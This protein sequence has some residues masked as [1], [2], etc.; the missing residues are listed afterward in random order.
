M[1]V[2]RGAKVFAEDGIYENGNVVCRD[3]KIAEIGGANADANASVSAGTSVD[4]H[5][6]IFNFPSN[7]SVIPG[8]IDMHLHGALGVDTMDATPQALEKICRALPCEGVTAFLATTITQTRDAITQ[9]VQSVWD[10]QQQQRCEVASIKSMNGSAAMHGA[11]AELL[12]INLEGPFIAPQKAC[13]H[14]PQHIVAPQ[15]AWL[16]QWHKTI[17]DGL[18]VFTVAPEIDGAKKLIEYAVKHNIV[19]SIGHSAATYEEASAALAAGCS[20]ATHLFNAFAPLHHRAPGAVTA[21]LL[22]P[23]ATVEVIADGIHLH[24]SILQLVLRLKGAERVILVSDAIRAKGM[25]DGEY[26]L[27]GQKVRV[28]KGEARVGDASD[29]LAGSVLTMDQALRNMMKFTGCSLQDVIKMTATNAAKR[30]GVFARKGTIAP[31]KDADLV[32][33]S[34]HHEVVLTVCRGLVG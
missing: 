31:H 12:G 9:A 7:Y 18:K 10:Y 23:N 15:L 25:G 17:R 14:L 26:E 34:E 19:A 30:L 4:A 16:Q 27:G 28:H 24:P 11:Q 21:L 33:L 3:G 5:A 13:A 32:V 20:H 29:V 8:M 22:D 1:I 6:Q 2:I